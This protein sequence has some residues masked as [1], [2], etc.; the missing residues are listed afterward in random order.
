MP[1]GAYYSAQP[2]SGKESFPN[3]QSEPPQI[4][5]HAVVIF[6]MFWGESITTPIYCSN[7]VVQVFTEEVNRLSSEQM[8]FLLLP[9]SAFQNTPNLMVAASR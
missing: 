6:C 4:Q 3:I 9:H 5:L 7:L 8:F 1:Q 2:H